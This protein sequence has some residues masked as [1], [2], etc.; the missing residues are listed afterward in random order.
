VR[1]LLFEYKKILYEK[2]YEVCGTDAGATGALDYRGNWT[3]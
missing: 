3:P 2:Q 1:R